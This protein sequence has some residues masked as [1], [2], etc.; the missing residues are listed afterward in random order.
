MTVGLESPLNNFLGKAQHNLSGP[1]PICIK[2]VDGLLLSLSENLDDSQFPTSARLF[3]LAFSSWRSGIIL[4]QAGAGSQVPLCMRHVVETSLYS[5]LFSRSTEWEDIWWTRETNSASKQ[6]MR[7]GKQGPLK[8]SREL[9]KSEN[10]NLFRFVSNSESHFIDFGAHPNVFQLVNATVV[11]DDDNAETHLTAFLGD[12]ESRAR[13]LISCLG[14]GFMLSEF[15]ETIW[16]LR[17]D[18]CNGAGI[19]AEAFGQGNLYIN[20]I[21]FAEPKE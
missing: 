12:D 9:L 10:E 15:F 14:I 7:N 4:A 20:A 5:Y 17:F 6:R 8:R 3:H 13:S 21:R 16:P 2:L 11:T 1:L 18:I 19:R